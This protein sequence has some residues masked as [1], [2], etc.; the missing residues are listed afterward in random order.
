MG[1]LH[2][3]LRI[4]MTIFRS[5]L[6]RM[7]SDSDERCRGQNTFYTKLLFF[8]KTCRLLNNEKKCGRSRQTTEDNIGQ[9]MHIAYCTNKATDTHSEYVIICGNKMPTRCNR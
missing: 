5:L 6:L 4:F 2:V 7:K 3:D 9:R 1:T 8:R